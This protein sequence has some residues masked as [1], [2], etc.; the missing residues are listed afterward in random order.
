MYICVAYCQWKPRDTTRVSARN[1][2]VQFD[3][4]ALE[5]PALP[6]RIADLLGITGIGDV[7]LGQNVALFP[8]AGAGFAADGLDVEAILAE[9]VAVHALMI[10]A[11]AILVV[12]HQ[13]LLPRGEVH[14]LGI[15]ELVEESGDG[16]VVAARHF[17]WVF[18]LMV[19]MN[20]C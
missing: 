16:L 20:A 4:V 10:Q 17:A 2:S 3:E 19:E 7:D 6:Q 9:A 14:Q 15:S 12:L 8:L 18:G 11:E 13:G 5:L 1:L